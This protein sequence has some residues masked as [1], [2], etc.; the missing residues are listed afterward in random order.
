MNKKTASIIF[1]ASLLVVFLLAPFASPL[2]DGL[3]KVAEM[4]GFKKYE[5]PPLV[6]VIFPDYEATFLK[7]PY[8]KLVLPGTFGV[9]LTF[10]LTSAVYLIFAKNKN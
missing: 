2:P 7:S 1:A 9:A 3:E 6:K 8:L 4:H 5:K 10:V